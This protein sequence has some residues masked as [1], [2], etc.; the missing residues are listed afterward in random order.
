MAEISFADRY[1]EIGLAPGA[2]IIA[3]RSAPAT[4]IVDDA[5]TQHI[6]AMV[7]AYFEIADVELEWFCEQFRQEDTAFSLVNN[8]REVRLLCAAILDELIAANDDVAILSVVTAHGAGCRLPKEFRWL[9]TRAEQALIDCAVSSRRAQTVDPKVINTA[10]PKLAEEIAAI[11]N[12]DWAGLLSALG[13]IR[14]EATSSVRTTAGQT[15]KALTELTRQVKL[16]REENQMLWW[17]MGGYSRALSRPFDQFT[18]SQTAIIAAT[19]LGAL[20]ATSRLGPVAAGAMLDRMIGTSKKARGQQEKSLD[21]VVDS[22]DRDDLRKLELPVEKIPAPLSLISTA[23][24]LARDLGPGA[25]QNRFRDLTGQPA[26][27]NIEPVAISEL[28][29]REI[30]LG[31][32]L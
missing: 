17:L 15:T 1:A 30:L 9:V 11:T 3:A 7:K 22:L 4:R 21:A 28:L 10:T 32:L 26:S 29:Y 14:N 12:G 25:W 20:T 27:L 5:P 31:Q 19:D 18:A 24:V 16:Q 6:F 8:E 23:L 2:D 13:K